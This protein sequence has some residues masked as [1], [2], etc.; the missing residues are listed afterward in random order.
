MDVN[1]NCCSLGPI[2]MK[3]DLVS[4][5]APTAQTAPDGKS[6]GCITTSLTYRF[7]QSGTLRTCRSEEVAQT[8]L[9]APDEEGKGYKATRK[10]RPM[11]FDE[12][13]NCIA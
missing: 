2:A 13:S 11:G 7:L 10:E 3:Q 4:G 9:T 1:P 5:V 6:Q 12:V 8:A